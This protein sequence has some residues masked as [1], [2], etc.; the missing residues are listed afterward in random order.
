MY[1]KFVEPTR[2][3][4]DCLLIPAERGT[5]ERAEQIANILQ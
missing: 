5:P 1:R 4:A 2:A 3:F